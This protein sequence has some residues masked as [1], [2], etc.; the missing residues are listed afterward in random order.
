MYLLPFLLR[1][2]GKSRLRI[3]CSACLE[4]KIDYPAPNRIHLYF[5]PLFC[6]R[7]ELFVAYRER[8]GLVVGTQLTKQ[9]KLRAYIKEYIQGFPFMGWMD[10]VKSIYFTDAWTHPLHFSGNIQSSTDLGKSDR[11]NCVSN[12]VPKFSAFPPLMSLIWMSARATRA[13]ALNYARHTHT[14]TVI[15]TAPKTHGNTL[16]RLTF[17]PFFVIWWI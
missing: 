10:I 14:H 5:F 9:S 1:P 11:L 17:S 6:V 4:K 3:Q 16:I 7:S 12:G 15:P 13:S 2:H 8:S